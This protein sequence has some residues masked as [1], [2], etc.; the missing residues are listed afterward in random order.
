VKDGADRE[1]A[2]VGVAFL[3]IHLALMGGEGTGA[4]D[5]RWRDFQPVASAGE[6]RL[7]PMVRKDS[8]IDSV[9][10]LLKR[11][12]RCRRAVEGVGSLG[13]GGAATGPWRRDPGGSRCLSGA[14]RFRVPVVG[15][16]Y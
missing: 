11:I 8:G 4:L 15:D 9:E 3:L 6:F 1:R 5:F 2:R 14:G 16:G 10:A 13:A 7:M 12:A